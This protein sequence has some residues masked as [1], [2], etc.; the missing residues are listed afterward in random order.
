MRPC[1]AVQCPEKSTKVNSDKPESR[2]GF[3]TEFGQGHDGRT[4]DDLSAQTLQQFFARHHGASSGDQVV[5]Q[6]HAVTGFDGVG[7][8]LDGGAAVFEFVGFFHR[9]EGQL[10]FLRI[11]TKPTPSS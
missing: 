9:G 2:N 8:Q 1:G 6:Q 7:V 3:T 10:A 5:D 11:G 4:F